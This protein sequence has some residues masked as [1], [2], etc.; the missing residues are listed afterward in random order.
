[1]KKITLGLIGFGTIGSGM[2][3]LL[4]KNNSEIAKRTG[5]NLQL[6]RI[7]DLDLK[8]D[9][10][11]K[12]KKE[13]LTKK[14]YDII[15]DPEV[16]I[17]IELMGGINK[18][19]EFVKKALENGKHVVT[20]NKALMSKKGKEL[21]EIAKK[22]NKFICFEA[23]VAGGIPIMKIIRESLIGNKIKKIMGIIN[24]TTNFILTKMEEQNLDFK[25]ALD[26]AQKKGFA[27]VDPTLDISGEDAAHK[28]QILA[29]HAFNTYIPFEKIHFEGITNI[30]IYDILYVKELGYKIKLLAIAKLIKNKIDCR[31]QPII[32]PENHLLASVRN[33]YN[34]IFIDGDASAPQVYYG[35]GAGSLP[36]ASAVVADIVDIAKSIIL[37]NNNPSI[38]SSFYSIKQLI[39]HKKISSRY[40]LRFH[41]L[42]KPGVLSK[43]SKILGDNNISLRSV[44]QKETG[45]KIVPIV[46]LTHEANEENIQKAI[47]KIKALDIVKTPVKIIRIENDD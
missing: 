28:I 42:D 14:A 7:A 2:I 22:N 38:Q 4:K 19:F 1:M 17:V 24:G 6:K 41:T 33:E 39:N 8:T 43:I 34:A 46:M 47:K 32:I 10:G 31:V 37:N 20:A 35:K 15:N 11:V 21:Y 9:R 13:K 36:T 23:S 30:D 44:L 29:S 5:I 18:A 45:Q 26:L 27:E 12:I 3:K 40:Y 16:D 25:E